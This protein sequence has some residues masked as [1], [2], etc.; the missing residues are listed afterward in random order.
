MSIAT[1]VFGY[2]FDEIFKVLVVLVLTI[3]LY[4]PYIE[5]STPRG[6]Y[7]LKFKVKNTKT[8]REI[9]SKLTMRESEQLHC[10]L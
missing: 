4:V 7:V 1:I 3:N 10:K 6:I 5:K 8:R 9:C 2:F